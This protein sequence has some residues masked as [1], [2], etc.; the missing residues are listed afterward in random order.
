MGDPAMDPVDPATATVKTPVNTDSTIIFGVKFN[1]SPFRKHK[2]KPITTR[3][4]GRNGTIKP[5][6]ATVV[7]RW[8]VEVDLSSWVWHCRMPTLASGLIF[9]AQNARL[10][11]KRKRR[12][13]CS[14]PYRMG[15]ARYE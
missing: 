15:W 5:A 10:S 6:Y 14:S 4:S 1:W 13:D 11:T 2:A 9:F 3:F 12:G 8:W 7:H